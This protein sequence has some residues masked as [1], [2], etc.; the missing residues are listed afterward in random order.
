MR[1][2]NKDYLTA[3]EIARFYGV[4]RAAVYSAIKN[5]R[6]KAVQEK[7]HWLIPR[8]EIQTYT[9]TR[10]SRAFSKYKGELTFDKAKGEYSITEAAIHLKCHPNVLY[11][12]CRI[13]LIPHKR[14]GAAYVLHIDDV[15]R[16]KEQLVGR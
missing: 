12:A 4:G 5:G 8:E 14:K 10:Y 13:K 7:K 1:S 11:H 6:L 15:E 3:A 2:P 16:F 9:K